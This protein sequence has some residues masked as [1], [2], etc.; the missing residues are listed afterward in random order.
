MNQLAFIDAY[1]VLTEP[2]TLTIQRL[3]PGPVERIWSYL[4]DSELRRK[5]LA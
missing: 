5:W 4:T 1:G 2:T 3:L